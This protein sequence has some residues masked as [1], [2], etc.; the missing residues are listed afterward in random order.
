MITDGPEVNR[1]IDTA[2]RAASVAPETAIPQP[3]FLG[4]QF[5]TR[6]C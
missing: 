5:R 2:A 6:Q 1:T 3:A 4:A